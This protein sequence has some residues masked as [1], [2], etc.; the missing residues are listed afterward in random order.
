MESAA[1]L[2]PTMWAS[3]GAARLRFR[4]GLIVVVFLK[5]ELFLFV[6]FPPDQMSKRRDGGGGVGP[7]LATSFLF[8]VNKD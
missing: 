1:R 5:R 4:S 8:L 7:R 3:A 2:V 6:T